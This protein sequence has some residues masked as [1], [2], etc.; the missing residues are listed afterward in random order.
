MADATGLETQIPA[1]GLP[2][3][4]GGSG[5]GLQG[6]HIFG[7]QFVNQEGIWLQDLFP[8]VGSNTGSWP[9]NF[10][11]LGGTKGTAA[12]LGTSVHSGQDVLAYD[13]LLYNKN[14]SSWVSGW[15]LGDHGVP[16]RK[17]T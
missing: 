4:T 8:G 16:L 11:Q 1:Y 9:W 6:A 7:N 10:A 12:A 15:W 5:T 2:R 14:G 17:G 13:A 3:Q